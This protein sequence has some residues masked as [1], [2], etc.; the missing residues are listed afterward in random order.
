MNFIDF[1][2]SKIIKKRIEKLYKIFRYEFK[3]ASLDLDDVKQ[4]VYIILWK[5]YKMLKKQNKSDKDI[6]KYLNKVV[7]T[8]IKKA[9]RSKAN[10]YYPLLSI[11]LIY[12]L[13]SLYNI[14]YP[15]TISFE[16]IKDLCS[17]KEYKVLF[18]RF[19]EDKNYREIGKEL[20]ITTQG[21][22][23]VYRNILK[24][25]KKKIKILL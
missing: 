18:K 6:Y 3:S 12:D 7:T 13:D 23:W 5:K 20:N 11:E 17:E 1:Y 8:R 21:A 4:D 19:K 15:S 22:Y 16:N 14:T 25:L 10:K 24:K 2:K 9:L